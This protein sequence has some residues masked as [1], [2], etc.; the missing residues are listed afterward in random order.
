MTSP[1]LRVSIRKGG[2]MEDFREDHMI[3]VRGL[4]QNRAQ[5]RLLYLLISLVFVYSTDQWE[6]QNTSPVC[7]GAKDGQFGRFYVKSGYKKLAA[8]SIWSF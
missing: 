1:N 4:Q 6:K 5:S 3:F 2:V 7:F 8:M